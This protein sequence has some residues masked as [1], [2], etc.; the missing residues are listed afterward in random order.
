MCCERSHNFCKIQLIFDEGIIEANAN[1]GRSV[2]QTFCV[3]AFQPRSQPPQKVFSPKPVLGKVLEDYMR[4]WLR[5]RSC[6]LLVQLVF[7][8]GKILQYRIAE[9]DNALGLVLQQGTGQTG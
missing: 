9:E 2:P 8:C 3:G 4:F 1:E 5:V 6:Q 7:M